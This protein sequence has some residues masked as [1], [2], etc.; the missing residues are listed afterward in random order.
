VWLIALHGLRGRRRLG[1]LGTVGVLALAALAI[2]AGLVVSG[3]GGTLLDRV[4]AGADVA[5]LVVEGD[6][7]A[8]AGV[9][10][11]PEVVAHS[12][13]FPAVGEAA[14]MLA[15]D[16]VSM[17]VTGLDTP[18]VEVNRPP[19]REGRWAGGPGEIV[20]D[21]SAGVELGI[22]VGDEVVVRN[23]GRDTTFRVVGT[24]ISLVDCFYPQCDPVRAW[25]TRA[26][27]ERI[28]TP[29][30]ISYQGWLRFDDPGQADP[31]VQRMA[32][33]GVTGIRGTDSW[34][35]TRQDFLAF[36][37][38]FGAFVAAFGVFVL[39]VAAV[40]IAGSAAMR[41]VARR[42]EIG[43]L[44]SIGCAPRQIVSA[45]VLENLALGAV[46]A[47]IGWSLAG[48]LAPRLQL[49]IGRTIG[50]QGPTWSWPALV[51]CV[52]VVCGSLVLATIAPAVA[53][54]RRPVTDVVRDVPT[55]RV[56]WVNRRMRSL[57]RRMA[58][59]G[60]RE[61]ASQ[62]TRAV[63]ASAAIVVA[64]VGTLVS[65][66][67]V[68][69]I[70]SVADEPAL[71]GSPWGVTV[72][73]GNTPPDDVA[74]MIERAPGVRAWYTEWPRRSTYADGAFLSVAMGGPPA[75]A[76]HDVV[77][78]RGLAA[79]GEA[80][81]GYGFLERFDVAVG[82]EIT[83]LAGTVPV[84]LE[85]VGWYR[86]TEDSGEMLRY[87][88]E[89]LPA[90]GDFDEPDVYRL[91]VDEGTTPASVAAA[92]ASS[93][94][95][96]SRTE[97]VDSGTEDLAPLQAALWLIAVVLLL[98]A[99][100]NVLSILATSSRESTRRV[101]VELALGFSPRQVI[102][103]GA[104]SGG[105]LGAIGALVGVP[106]GLWI[107]R[108]LSNVVSSSI[109]VGPGWMP[110]PGAVP[111]VGVVVVVTI[112]CAGLGALSVARNA[113]TPASELVRSE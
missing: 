55:E 95:P 82:D 105:L 106:L 16:P 40:V 47:V 38:V 86:E 77:E 109:G 5:H 65:I 64:V 78:G 103:S 71:A 43:L 34:L 91:V 26:G 42:R 10:S 80:I 99:G 6:A 61:T 22:D 27:L 112:A 1:L 36:D 100:A 31:F 83:I 46:G 28:A 57:P 25:M 23:G 37:R 66:G 87:R 50:T 75:A 2:A 104:I 54:A 52:V 111:A 56:S 59:L 69:G 62:P 97:V 8:I 60:A 12:G 94:G 85:I 92:L 53:A 68:R 18:D 35:D 72:V 98:M 4:A 90:T 81:A 73:P 32:A 24:A 7:D 17:S 79:P 113:R 33:T 11:D 51:V 96:G 88:V 89:S 84:D 101:G 49:G 13:P 108:V 39:V 44:G 14:L 63:L 30:S 21:R 19:V 93:L 76:E 70:S 15:G 110:V 3:Q 41:V 74:E 29:D 67:F 107:F 102:A 58:W 48:F 45:L 20:L 9:A